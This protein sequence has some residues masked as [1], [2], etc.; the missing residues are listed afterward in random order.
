MSK[1]NLPALKNALSND[2][3]KK[4]F[5]EMLGKKSAGFIS[6]IINVVNSNDYLATADPNSI[7]MSAAVAATLDL[8]INPN[9]GFAY[10]VPYNTK[11]KDGSFKVMAQFQMGYKGFVQL[12]IR[13][14]QYK[15]MHVCPIFEGEMK[16]HDRMTGNVEIDYDSKKSDKITGYVAC[17]SMINGFEK[18]LYMTKSEVETHGKAYSKSYSSASGRW[19]HD[20]NAM[21][22]KTVLKRLLSK[23]GL[24]SIELQTAITSDQ[25]VISDFEGN[26]IDYPDN[27]EARSFDAH[28]DVTAKGSVELFENEHGEIV[29][30][31]DKKDDTGK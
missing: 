1:N 13:S 23:Y 19:Q 6:S 11:Q 15:S 5:E 4:R 8:P 27:E 18:S 30:Q 14:G 10:I 28:E 2:G 22:E 7:I 29:E 16:K 20:F 12:A 25:G 26:K 3:I 31:K 24:L 17:F 21:A 9:L